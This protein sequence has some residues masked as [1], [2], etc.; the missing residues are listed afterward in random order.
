MMSKVSRGENTSW[1]KKTAIL[2]WSGLSIH[3][4]HDAKTTLKSIVAGAAQTTLKVAGAK[5][6]KNAG[7]ADL[8]IMSIKSVDHRD[9]RIAF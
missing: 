2:A 8:K 7:Y 9:V 4:M 1:A 5:L 3:H 6:T